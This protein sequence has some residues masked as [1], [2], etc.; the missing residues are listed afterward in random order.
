ML[1]YSTYLSSKV[2]DDH[3]Q[4]ISNH[5]AMA[6]IGSVRIFFESNLVKI[7]IKQTNIQS[8]PKDT[9]TVQKHLIPLLININPKL[10]CVLKEDGEVLE[11]FY[12]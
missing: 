6:G 4:S 2:C 3:K 8:V 7:Y 10:F 1:R 9:A 12:F 5:H 11:S